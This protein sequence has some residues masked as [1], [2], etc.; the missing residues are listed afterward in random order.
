MESASRQTET[1]FTLYEWRINLGISR[2]FFLSRPPVYN[3]G[4]NFEV[5]YDYDENA[6]T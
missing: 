2:N 5:G 4:T 1:V 3:P 6:L